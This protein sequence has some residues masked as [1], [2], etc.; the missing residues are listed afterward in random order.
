[1]Q[2]VITEA[3]TVEDLEI[4]IIEPWRM[5]VQWTGT[6][7]AIAYEVHVNSTQYNFKMRVRTN[8]GKFNT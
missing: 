5:V 8:K 2:P 6:E 1:M 4:S 3:K 7:K